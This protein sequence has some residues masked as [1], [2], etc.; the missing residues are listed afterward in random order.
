[1]TK[2]QTK[3]AHGKMAKLVHLYVLA[4]DAEKYAKLKRDTIADALKAA[5]RTQPDMTLDTAAGIARLHD[6]T[7]SRF[8]Q[9]KAKAILG[10]R[11]DECYT[12]ST[13]STLDVQP[14]REGEM[15]ASSREFA[16]VTEP[17]NVTPPEPN[18]AQ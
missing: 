14:N 1:M 5:L 16:K 2:Q 9:K 4:R 7:Q 8:D 17:D 10:P 6:V 13:T 12:E 15:A 3:S 11:F 18:K